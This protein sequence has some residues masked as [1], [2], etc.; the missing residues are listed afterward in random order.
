MNHL[1][2][3]PIELKLVIVSY[4]DGSSLAL[5]SMTSK[6]N[7]KIKK[8]YLQGLAPLIK[9]NGTWM[10]PELNTIPKALYFFRTTEDCEILSE[11]IA[12][13]SDVLYIHAEIVTELLDMVKGQ[14]EDFDRS[15][16][17]LND[18][19]NLSDLPWSNSNIKGSVPPHLGCLI[20]L[21]RMYL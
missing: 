18:E 19:H 4:L 14:M 1:S 7:L 12:L 9:R 13:N 21:E 16:W 6:E 5:F 20:H 10:E 2:N 3:F 11:L 8:S 15:G 17:E